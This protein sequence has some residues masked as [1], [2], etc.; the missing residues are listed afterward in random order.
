MSVFA[1]DCVCTLL[2]APLQRLQTQ[3]R[4]QSLMQAKAANQLQLL[5]L[6][7]H[8]AP[9]AAMAV[10]ALQLLS[11]TVLKSTQQAAQK[12]SRPPRVASLLPPSLQRPRQQQQSQLLQS[13]RCLGAATAPAGVHVCML[14]QL[15]WPAR[16]QTGSLPNTL[17]AAARAQSQLLQQPQSPQAQKRAAQ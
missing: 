17:A 9:A 8:P 16:L 5:L 12:G 4:M 1:I 11:L 3:P 7:S 2:P 14:A 15:Q 10:S 13:L 6:L